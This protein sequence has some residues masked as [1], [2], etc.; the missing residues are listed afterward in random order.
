MTIALT[1]VFAAERT[2]EVTT[3]ITSKAFARIVDKESALL[4]NLSTYDEFMN[5]AAI[6][7]ATSTVIGKAAVTLAN[8]NFFSNAATAF[9][10]TLTASNMIDDDV[11]S[12][13]SYDVTVGASAPLRSDSTG[14]ITKTITLKAAGSTS[15]LAGTKA[16]IVDVVDADWDNAAAGNYTGILTFNFETI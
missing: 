5:I 11:D 2:L 1:G 8:L 3:E 12:E 13:I 15:S 7:D 14:S 16:I 6:A 9:T 4:V 10:T